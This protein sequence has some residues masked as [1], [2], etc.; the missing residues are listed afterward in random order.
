MPPSR[1]PHQAVVSTLLA[2]SPNFSFG[3]CTNVYKPKR[4]RKF[5]RAGIEILTAKPV[6][7]RRAIVATRRFEELKI[8]IN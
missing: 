1:R 8:D 6:I 3:I 5:A 2:I 4:A 7:N